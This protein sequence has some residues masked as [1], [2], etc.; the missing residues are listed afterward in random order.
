MGLAA[1]WL[2]V[3][4]AATKR[5]GTLIADNDI[6]NTEL[7]PKTTLPQAMILSTSPEIWAA[8]GPASPEQEILTNKL[9]VIQSV[10]LCSFKLHSAKAALQY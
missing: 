8:S 10:P 2:K 5:A 1:V 3:P 7:K 4:S 9:Q 6:M